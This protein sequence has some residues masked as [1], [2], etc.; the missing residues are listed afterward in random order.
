MHRIVPFLVVFALSACGPVESIDQT[1]R[2]FD[3]EETPDE[4]AEVA[5]EITCSPSIAVYP[6]RG[7]HNNG[8]DS[9]A[10]N[11]SQWTCD[12]AHSNSDFVA[13]DHLGNDIWADEGTPVVATASGTLVMTGWSSY[14][15][16][17]VTIL[18]AC[19]WYHFMCHLQKLAPGIQ[20]GARVSAGQVIGYV[21]KTGTASNG[22]VHLHYSLYP[23]NNYNA[24]IDPWS[25][26]HAVEANVCSSP[27]TGGGGG[28][29]T[30]ALSKRWVDTFAS[31]N[32]YA[33][34]TTSSTRRGTLNAGTNYVFC[35]K[36]G[37]Q[38]RVGSSY[39]SWWLLTD[40]DHVVS[41]QVGRAWVSAYYLSR[42]GNDQAKDNSGHDIPTCP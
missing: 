4:T 42:W 13:G 29:G 32:G 40:L 8:Y 14:S 24:G 6:V 28:G 16:N 37:A 1:D 5:Q 19:G 7:K 3:S 20:N 11:H 26:L 41:G 31:A 35:K 10:G 12:A 23:N 2:S 39:N 21:G 22:V 36:R 34:T 18:D 30:P 27:S 33:S 9:T 25:R 15:G 17:K 38:V